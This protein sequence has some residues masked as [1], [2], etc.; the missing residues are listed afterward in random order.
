MF[1]RKRLP[2][3]FSTATFQLPL[4]FAG[5]VFQLSL[6]GLLAAV[7]NAL[8]AQSPG[9]TQAK[10]ASQQPSLTLN[11]KRLSKLPNSLGVA[12]AFAGLSGETVLAGGGANFPDAP[13]WEGG[14]KVWHDLVYWMEPETGQWTEAGRLP[15]PL[16]YGVSA[17]CPDGILCVGGSDLQR[18]Y[19]E[20]F[21]LRWADGQLQ[22]T[23]L[24]KLPLPLA[25]S[26]GAIVGQ[27]LFLCGGTQ[28]PD[29]EHPEAGLWSLDLSRADAEWSREPDCPGGPRLLAV[30][31][32]SAEE[33]FVFG[34]TDLI[35]GKD[36]KSERRYRSDAWAFQPERGWRRLADLPQPLVAA[37]S[38]APVLK[39]GTITLLGGDSGEHIGFQPP[40]L[41][42]GF[43]RRVLLY[44]PNEN[45]WTISAEE[46][47]L[48]RVTAPLVRLS[49]G[50][51]LISG[52]QR[53]GV[54]SP[55]VWQVSED[56]GR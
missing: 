12:G 47:P 54:R 30:A 2:A 4:A 49:S 29:S 16:G 10:P 15:R 5:W 9:Q 51:L 24:P 23:S 3:R 44:S 25:N 42:P 1:F 36:G 17:T 56:Q 18:H 35:A 41:H 21:K 6:V 26:C 34:G 38:P 55:E 20:C 33:L 43:S 32:G 27:S 11:W 37:P 7:D 14:R 13:P 48:A 39:D 31:A 40:Q 8:I 46:M 53:P 45:A 50:W 19:A 52:E 22:V 28:A